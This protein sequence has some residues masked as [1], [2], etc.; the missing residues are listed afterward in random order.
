MKKIFIA[1]FVLLS[2]PALS[3]AAFN[4]N[5]SYGAR[6]ANVSELQNFLINKGFLDQGLATG[7]FLSMTR[8]AVIDYQESVGVPPTGFV[9]PLTRGQINYEIEDHTPPT[10]FT[11][12]SPT[13]PPPTSLVPVE[14]INPQPLP[15]PI[16]V[17]APTTAPVTT[18]SIPE[19]INTLSYFLNTS[20]K[21]L[22][23]SHPMNQTLA[24][25]TAYYVKWASDSYEIYTYDNN[26]IYLSED[27]S[28]SPV[29][30]SYTFSNGKWL[31]ISM[32]VGEQINAQDNMIQNYIVNSASCVPSTKASFPYTT[33]LLEHIP[34]YDAGGQLGI[35]DVIVV[36]YDYRTSGVSDYE[37]SY[38]AKGLG[39]IKW[40]L[41]RN[42]TLIQ[43]SSFNQFSNATPLPPALGNSCFDKPINMTTVLIP[44]N[45]APAVI[46]PVIS[47][48]VTP[49]PI[50]VITASVPSIPTSLNAFVH[51]LYSCVLNNNTPD[52]VG[53][54]FW[55]GNLQTG[56]LTPYG[57]YVEFF[58]YQKDVVPAITDDQFTKKLYSC[59]LFRPADDVSYANVMQ[60]L[61]N[62]SL[63]REG[64]VQ[65]VLNS[66]EFTIGILPKLKLLK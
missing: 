50:P 13:I 5:L 48:T 35:Q 28:G 58:R 42:N 6:G 60:G 37:K 55:L 9:G 10:V 12:T 44:I 38:Y 32:K 36:L 40:E 47:P 8:R 7:N 2:F 19:T 22:T 57:I 11:V 54:N 34:K 56:A 43:T 20:G 1:L 51:T 14:V 64:L 21:A 65:T 18:S 26:Y 23:G 17:I 46:V 29:P 59:M 24:G 66:T 25:N 61:G 16:P 30:G 62:G 45:P 3:F 39:W 4:I 52:S 33:T 49:A 15:L 63:T 53:I 27:H 41:Y 31:K